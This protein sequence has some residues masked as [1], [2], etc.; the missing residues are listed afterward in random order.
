MQRPGFCQDVFTWI[1]T[2]ATSLPTGVFLALVLALLSRQSSVSPSK[3]HI[4]C[5]SSGT[6]SLQ[7]TLPG[8]AAVRLSAA[9]DDGV[10]A[11]LGVTMALV[12][13]VIKTCT[14]CRQGIRYQ[15]LASRLRL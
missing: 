2:S 4:R 11:A 12:P 5:Y 6:E 8:R 13:L 10:R 1:V 14:C 15:V 9:V 3:G 7:A